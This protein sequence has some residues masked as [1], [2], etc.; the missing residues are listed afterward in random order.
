MDKNEKKEVDLNIEEL[1]LEDVSFDL[2]LNSKDI[3][4]EPSNNVSNNEFAEVSESNS[5]DLN[6]VKAQNIDSPVNPDL[7]ENSSPEEVIND[8]PEIL[9]DNS[10]DND[11]SDSDE[12]V[13]SDSIENNNID[14]RSLKEKISDT[15]EK[16][17]N[18]PEDI[19]NKI[20]DAKEKIDNTKEKI[21]NT[22]EDIKNKIN[23]TKDKI[24]DTKEKVKNAPE[25]IKNK[26]NKAKDA[27]NNRPKNFKEFKDKAKNAGSNLKDKAK[28]RA[29]NAANKA[30]EKAQD[31]AQDAWDNSDLN[32]KL[33]NAKKKVDK[34]KKIANNTKK[35]G[36]AVAKG[37][38]IAGKAA[39]N[40][41]K[42][43]LDLII[44]TMP[45]SAIVIAV[46][47]VI[48]LVV[49]LILMY[50]PGS[51]GN[52]NDESRYSTYSEKD[53]KT[54]EEL[55]EL[56]KKYPNADGSLAMATV[57]YPY[58]S[59]FHTNTILT[60]I[61]DD[62]EEVEADDDDE[63]EVEATDDVEAEG[64]A[65]QTD[66]MEMD[67]DMYLYP[68][69]KNKMR[70]K[71]EAVLKKLNE[72]NE[73][74][75]EEYLINDYF[76]SDKGYVIGYDKDILTGYKG[77]KNMINNVESEKQE[78]FKK[79][80]IDEINSIKNL[81]VNYVFEN[82]VCS[83]TLVDAGNVTTDKLLNSTV[84]IDLKKPG[85]SQ[86]SQCSESYYSEFLT[87]EEYAKGVVYEE[88]GSETS[89]VEV[90]AAQMVAAKNFA[91]AR[92]PKSV[93]FSEELN[94]YVIPMLWSTADQDFCHVE[95]GCNSSDITAHHGYNKPAGNTQ[96]L[97]HGANRAPAS[98]DRKALL[99]QAWENSKST[100]VVK[101]G[102]SEN[103]YV[104]ATTSYWQGSGCNVGN[105]MEQTAL[106]SKTGSGMDHKS[107]LSYFYSKYS[108]A[109]IENEVSTLQTTGEMVCTNGMS[110]FTAERNKISSLAI[111][112]SEQNIPY[113]IGGIAS[114][115]NVASNKFG[116]ET[117]PDADGNDKIGLGE[118]G[119]VNF[120]F[121]N[122]INENFGNT[123]DINKIINDETSYAIKKENLLTGDIGISSDNTII[124]IY[125]GDEKWAYADAI[126]KK[127]VVTVDD[128][129]VTFR[130][131]QYFKN[132]IYNFD[133]RKTIP[134]TSEWRGQSWFIHSDYNTGQCPWYAKNRASEIV[135]NLYSNSSI[136]TEVYNTIIKKI[137]NTY[138]NGRDYMPGSPGMYNFKN[139]STNID[140]IKAPAFIGMES[141]TAYG[142]PYG[143][144][145][146]IE[147][148]NPEED[149]IIVTDG[150]CSGCGSLTCSK[151][152]GCINFR[153][154]EY[155]YKSFKE[156]FG[157]KFRGYIYFME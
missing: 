76:M 71:L 16:I 90:L 108:L 95:K 143:H 112:L 1:K 47:L 105:C 74:S 83:T 44:S 129:F 10:L 97:M 75:F 42:G 124:A 123:N 117:T 26:A 62:T 37:A 2:N 9:D 109:T 125:I 140:D 111:T 135:N 91:I 58:Y 59:N 55:K 149:K 51:A 36:K 66:E 157:W 96:A 101:S 11:L 116:T 23:D 60:Y 155:T 127:V 68:L 14:D 35:A 88:L 3:K 114:Y 28:D 21:K 139:G 17:K 6:S 89:D 52:V 136:T 98:A 142:K 154:K 19:K 39:M 85:C 84:Y 156:Y 138:G 67:D 132:E 29:K 77:Y 115:K 78:E 65:D 153:Y 30:K 43:L 104:A 146:V 93:K 144:V 49:A 4:I 147:Y 79:L 92:R 8:L 82:A 20:E 122:V 86:L 141:N 34:A 151:T 99:D 57:L 81:F 70:K 87:M 45:W 18:T 110:N 106:V 48:I 27:W 63:E 113:Y 103:N 72:K 130:R 24:N 107:I 56:F 53:Q 148:A 22:P 33:Q 61:I 25:N 137:K 133:I 31:K 118:V 41:A 40:L 102:S 69:R 54:L 131:L 73:A 5:D 100:Y 80:L 64:T 46:I 13:S 32:K 119:F 12:N 7:N 128:R 150:W 120:V 126:S 152:F 121:W 50:V 145:A 38:K 94:A 134:T 15:K